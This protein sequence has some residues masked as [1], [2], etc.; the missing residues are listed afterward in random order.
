MENDYAVE[1]TNGKIRGYGRRGVIKF[2][3][4]PYAAPPVGDL[5]FKPPAPVEPWGGV[6]DT[7]EYSPIVPQPPAAIESMFG[8]QREQNEAECLTLNVWTSAIDDKKRPVMFFIHGGGF[9][10]GTG[11][12]LDGSRL[13]LRGDVVVVSI[14]YRLGTLGFLYMPDEPDAAANVGLQDMVAALKFVKDNISKFGGDSDNV[15]IFGESA[16][17]FAVASLLAMPSAKGLFHRAIPQSGAAHPLGFNAKAGTRVYDRLIEKLGVKKGDLDALRKISSE[18]LI[19]AQVSIMPDTGGDFATDRPLRLGPVVDKEILPEHPLDALRN[20]YAKEIDILVGS[21]LDETKLWNMWNPNADKIDED[22][23]FKGVN[24]IVGLTGKDEN[25]T[26]EL[27]EVY[28]EKRKTPRDIMDA[29]S[30]DYMFRIPSIR[31]A[32]TQCVHQ[33][34]TY[35]YLFTWQSPLKGGKYGAMHA[36]ELAFVFGVLLPKEIG[37]FPKKN[38]ETQAISDA[39]MD[40]WISFARSGNPNNANIPQFPQYDNKE[41]ATIIFDKKIEIVND[42]YGKERAAWIDLL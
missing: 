35:M 37:I 38:E 11:A 12:S 21:N 18:D 16:G 27:I 33:K 6:R 22:G 25:K 40:T 14:N 32:E 26:K 36:L 28:K 2:K 20:G 3:G 31:L 10:T 15:T 4:I 30:T 1:T 41:R 7:L 17:G 13:V 39:M 23:L 9:V 24:A 8:E 29:V 19:K 34:N 42:P 5:R